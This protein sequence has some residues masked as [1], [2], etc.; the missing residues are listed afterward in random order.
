MPTTTPK[1]GLPRPIASDNV[2]LVNQQALIDAIELGAAPINSPEL[3]GIPKAPTAAAGT[4]TDQI[5]T[6]K[7]LKAA[8]DAIPAPTAPTW[9]NITGKPSTFPPSAHGHA[10]TEITAT[11]GTHV[12]AEIDNLKSSVSSGKDAVARAITGMGQPASGGDTF[13]QMATKVSAISTDATAA[14]AD[15]LT[16]KTFYQGGVK[17]TGGMPNNGTP[18]IVPTSSNITLAAGYYGPTTTVQA[19]SVPAAKVLTGTT[20]A[21]TAGTMVNQAAVAPNGHAN[22]TQ[23]SFGAYTAGNPNLR[24]YLMPPV[25]FYDG[26]IWVAADTP[27]L[28]PSNVRRGISYLSGGLG[29]LNPS[30]FASGSTTVSGSAGSWINNNTSSAETF[31]NI[32]NVSGLTFLPRVI[33]MLNLNNGVLTWWTSDTAGFIGYSNSSMCIYYHFN[34]ST[35]NRYIFKPGGSMNV[36]ATGFS[37]PSHLSGT[38]VM[39]WAW[40]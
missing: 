5:A 23:I 1:L 12:Q 26:T 3:T 7:A 8:V 33:E 16:G 25:G 32:T 17:R 24:T 39:W 37:L 13:A 10:A 27:S 9:T 36:T 22:A 21:G 30:Y 31:P 4:N 28:D 38:S 35:Y 29:T 14:V 2:T 18:T 6:M 20:I 15:V 34:G 19:V 11:G 40:G